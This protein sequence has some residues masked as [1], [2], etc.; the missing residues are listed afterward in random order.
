MKHKAVFFLLMSVLVTID[1]Y[2]QTMLKKLESP[3][4]FPGD[5]ITAY[6]DPAILYHNKTFYL[7]F[8]LVEVEKDGKVFSYTATS[9][10]RDLKRWSKPVKITPRDQSLDFCSPG[11]VLRF[12]DEWVLCLQTYPRPGLYINQV[13]YGDA[14]AR[15]YTMRSRDLVSWSSPEIIRVKGNDVAVEDMGRMIDPYLVEDKDEKGK[16]WCFYKQRGVSMSYS[17]DLINWTFFGNTESGENTCVMT[18]NNEYILF[19]SPSNGIGIKKSSDLKTWKTWGELI[20]LGQDQWKWAKGRITAGA[21]INL[22]NVKGIE[23][24]L[25]FFHGSGPLRENEGDFDKNASIGIAWSS[26][27]VNWSWPGKK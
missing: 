19:H 6:R 15:I 4:I 10:S 14:T 22:K 23:R 20:T 7:F 17:H 3:V 5:S 24:Y 9:G 8:T 26:D 21:V 11:N 13:K 27:L 12:R 18:E 16:Y 25:M 2:A 1:M